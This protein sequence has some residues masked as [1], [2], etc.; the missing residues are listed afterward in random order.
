MLKKLNNDQI[1]LIVGLNVVNLIRDALTWE[2]AATRHKFD[3]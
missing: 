1:K 3:Q 2:V